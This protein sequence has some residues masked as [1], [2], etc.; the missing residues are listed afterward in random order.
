MSH[1]LQTNTNEDDKEGL[2]YWPE[3]NFGG[4]CA[5]EEKKTQ[6][7]QFFLSHL[8]SYPPTSPSPIM[9]ILFALAALGGL[10]VDASRTQTSLNLRQRHPDGARFQSGALSR[11]RFSAAAAAAASPANNTAPPV[12]Y[13]NNWAG[14]V[15]NGAAF[16]RV[17]GT[18]TVPNVT[19]GGDAAV[20]VWVGIDGDSCQ[21]SLLQTG[22]AFYGDGSYYAWFEWIPEAAQHFANFPVRVGDQ[23]TMAVSASGPRSGIA[24]MQ[25]ARTGK[26]VTQ[27]FNNAANPLCQADA[28]WIVEDFTEGQ[29]KVP[30]ANFGE[31]TF[32]NASA[33]GSQGLVEPSSGSVVDLRTPDGR[34]LA[35]C[36]IDG[37]NVTCKYI[38]DGS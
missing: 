21:G 2:I 22:L 19:G 34:A 30:F 14:A 3:P 28:E 15:L 33:Q 8:K 20:G 27:R 29:N 1:Y 12:K 7:C 4:M 38:G 11:G 35:D 37:T 17:E 24:T 25:N 9:R 32:T 16:T 10:L 18:I 5:V 26:K 6:S 23:I 13:S 31:I 36:S